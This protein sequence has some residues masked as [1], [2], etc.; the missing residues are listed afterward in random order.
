MGLMPE[1]SGVRHGKTPIL[2]VFFPLPFEVQDRQLGKLRER[3]RASGTTSAGYS[4][5]GKG[6]GSEPAFKA[7]VPSGR[8]GSLIRPSVDG[9]LL[10]PLRTRT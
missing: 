6:G 3:R 4:G 10:S 2:G 9:S 7:V 1:E 5:Y 8:V